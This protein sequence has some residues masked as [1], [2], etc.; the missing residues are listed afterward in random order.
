[1][2]V[3]EALGLCFFVAI[4][5]FGVHQL[6]S[7]AEKLLVFQ[8]ATFP[9]APCTLHTWPILL[10]CLVCLVSVGYGSF[11]CVKQEAQG[12]KG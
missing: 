12:Q 11:P 8:V 9:I 2:E 6:P 4:I 1:M 5:G 10:S 3:L 7:L